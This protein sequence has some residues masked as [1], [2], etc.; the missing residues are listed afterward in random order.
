MKAR[1]KYQANSDAF[2]AI[3]PDVMGGTPVIRG[4]RVTVYALLGRIEHGETVED[5]LSDY[6]DLTS[7]A[8]EAAIGY[9]RAHPLVEA[10]GGR[11][12]ANG[13]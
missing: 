5:I 3:D 12:W 11:P 4:T 10:P 8:I 1:D 7:E 2:I 6:P 9:A 13:R